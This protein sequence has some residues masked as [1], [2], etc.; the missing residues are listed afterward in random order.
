MT[1]SYCINIGTDNGLLIAAGTT[2]YLPVS[3]ITLRIAEGV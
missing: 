2:Q 3:M 1:K